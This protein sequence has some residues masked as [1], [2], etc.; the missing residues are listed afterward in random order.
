METGLAYGP[1]ILRF[2]ARVGNFER[3]YQ[4]NWNI[5]FAEFP[6]GQM[7]FT[8]QL[9]S[10]RQLRHQTLPKNMPPRNNS[11]QRRSNRKVE[12]TDDLSPAQTLETKES[13]DEKMLQKVM[14][15]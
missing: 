3:K 5:T 2:M 13:N 7:M 1:S 11:K 4:A 15:L 6:G 8:A 10:V 14:S 12:S 9:T